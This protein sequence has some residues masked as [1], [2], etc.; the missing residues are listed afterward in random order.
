MCSRSKRLRDLYDSVRVKTVKIYSQILA[1]QLRLACHYSHAGLFR[2]LRD[3]AKV[4]DWKAKLTDLK[5]MEESINNDLRTLGS[6]TLIV[7]ND[8]VSELQN[9]AS[10]S[11]ALLG[12]TR[13][14]VEV[15][16]HF[17]A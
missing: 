2:F 15:R 11:L 16:T 5:T 4:D 8:K 9:L 12:E 14:A 10:K 7:I 1:Y 3:V 6:H 17:E 13:V